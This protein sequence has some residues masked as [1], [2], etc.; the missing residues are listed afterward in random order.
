ML[1][2]IFSSFL[3]Q[4]TLETSSVSLFLAG[5]RHLNQFVLVSDIQSSV[6]PH[7]PIQS[8]YFSLISVNRE[9]SHFPL[10]NLASLVFSQCM[11]PSVK[12]MT[13]HSVPSCFPCVLLVA[14]VSYWMEQKSS[15]LYVRQFLPFIE[16]ARKAGG[17]RQEIYTSAG[18]PSFQCRKAGQ[19]FLLLEVVG[20][21]GFSRL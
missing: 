8:T 11:R 10:A 14:P 5:F 13:E 19:F 4:L 15:T 21:A 3:F 2:F 20:I 16:V 7:P 9:F 18:S 1:I 6:S 12:N 17:C